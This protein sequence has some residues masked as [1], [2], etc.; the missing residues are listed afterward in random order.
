MTDLTPSERDALAQ[1]RDIAPP[2]G[3]EAK[4]RAALRARGAIR[5]G[6]AAWRL[7]QFAAAAAAA[8]LVFTSGFFA[9]KGAPVMPQ[10]TP[11][12]DD[13]PQYVLFVRESA[14][15]L[16][17]RPVEQ[18][19]QEYGDWARALGAKGDLVDGWK[20]ADDGRTVDPSSGKVQVSAFGLEMG[21]IGGLFIVRAA[22]Y[23]AAVAIAE[24][25]PHVRY[26]GTMEVR[27]IDR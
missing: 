18:L 6:A 19:V 23:D 25:S 26:G 2:A 7:P 3:A 22:D 27:A 10:A 17:G 5:G 11:P 14:S 16:E 13:R 15:V 12:A 9:G 24:S 21:Q 8:A 20:L 4:I 1:L